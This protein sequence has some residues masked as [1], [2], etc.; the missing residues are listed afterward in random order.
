M[1]YQPQQQPGQQPA[2]GYAQ[3]GAPSYGQPAPGAAPA[4]GYGYAPAQPAPAAAGYG[5]QPAASPA[6]AASPGKGMTMLGAAVAAIG[7]IVG[8]ALI[9]MSGS[10]KEETVKKFARAP[11]GCT[12]SLEFDHAGNYTLYLETKGQVPN[13]GGDCAANGTTYQHAGGIPSVSVTLVD[14]AGT[15]VAT[16]SAAGSSYDEGGYAGSALLTAAVPAAGTYQITVTSDATDVAIAI[17][18]DPEGSAGTMKTI[19]FAV[20]AV[21]VLGGL[22]LILLGRK[23]NASPA[24][25]APAGGGWQPQQAATP[26]YQQQ[27]AYQQPPQQAPAQPQWQP[28]Q[29]AQ[30][31]PQQQAPAQPQW[32]QQPQQQPQ[33]PQQGQQQPPNG[34]WGGP[35]G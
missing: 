6:P 14:G 23:K 11:A 18:G 4:P 32:P 22:G 16:A 12:T 21:G 9:L 10:S 20:L 31:A 29:P 7:V 1:S 5:Y 19:G 17:G 8:L 27:P 35:T 3:P 13:L 33:W 25:A 30:Q 2:P 26:Q 34:G 15:A 24:A 28:Q